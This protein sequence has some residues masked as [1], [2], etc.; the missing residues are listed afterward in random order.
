LNGSTIKGLPAI[1]VDS[2]GREGT[3]ITDRPLA[4]DPEQRVLLL[5]QSGE[6]VLVPRQ[7]LVPQADGRY[8]LKASIEELMVEYGSRLQTGAQQEQALVV[9][10]IE[11]RATVDKRVIET[12]RVQIHKTVH[13]HT[14]VVDQPLQTEQVEIERVAIN[15]MIDEPMSIRHEGD[16]MIIPLLEE[17]LVVEKRLVLREEVHIKKLKSVVHDPQEVRLREERVEIVRNAGDIPASGQD[18]VQAQ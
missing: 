17:V 10:V 2:M 9:P 12:G 8:R 5:F 6:Q 11:E 7:L 1:V 15:R 13:E 14:E 3:I 4:A 16:T 18:E